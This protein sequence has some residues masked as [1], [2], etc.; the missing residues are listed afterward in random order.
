MNIKLLILQ[1]ELN[2]QLCHIKRQKELIKEYSDHP[3]RP[4]PKDIVYKK[5]NNG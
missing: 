3:Y 5:K 2:L 4:I 1:M